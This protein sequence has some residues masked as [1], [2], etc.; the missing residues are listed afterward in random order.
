[1]F[2]S[3]RMWELEDKF[4]EDLLKRS[5]RVRDSKPK[6]EKPPRPAPAHHHHH[7]HH[8]GCHGEESDEGTHFRDEERA[9]AELFSRSCAQ[10]KNKLKE[11]I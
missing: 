5:Q 3:K 6:Y 7:H 1:M 4:E 11:N 8:G 9:E 2:S 10:K